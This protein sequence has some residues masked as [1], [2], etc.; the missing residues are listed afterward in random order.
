MTK[1]YDPCDDTGLTDA[2]K[3][4]Y[5]VGTEFTGN[6]PEY[7]KDQHVGHC[8]S[9][10]PYDTNSTDIRTRHLLNLSLTDPLPVKVSHLDTS[11][12]K[13]VFMITERRGGWGFLCTYSGC[14]NL[15]N[16]GRQYFYL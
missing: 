11:L 9:P 12:N 16:T 1:C 8:W 13:D 3:W 10:C 14:T 2:E 6:L 4:R 5:T 15:I 7:K